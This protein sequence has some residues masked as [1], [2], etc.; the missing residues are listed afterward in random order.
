[1]TQELLPCPFCGGVAGYAETHRNHW[2]VE[3]FVC[4]VRHPADVAGEL[5]PRPKLITAWNTRASTADLQA[6]LDAADWLEGEMRR[7]VYD[8]APERRIAVLEA[9]RNKLGLP[10]WSA[11][12][13]NTEGN[14]A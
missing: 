10:M 11:T 6:R 5:D 4:G 12:A 3:C 1:M 2:H 7:Y 9:Y 8:A 14:E 13:R